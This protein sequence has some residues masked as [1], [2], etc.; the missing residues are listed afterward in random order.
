MGFNGID[1]IFNHPWLHNFPWGKLLNKEI[2]SLYIP[3]VKEYYYI[4]Y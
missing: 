4:E 2:R 1:E 3:G